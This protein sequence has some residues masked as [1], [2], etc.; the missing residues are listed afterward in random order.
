MEKLGVTN[1]T[2]FVKTVFDPLKT[3]GASDVYESWHLLNKERSQLMS[4]KKT[5]SH[6][7]FVTWAEKMKPGKIYRQL[8]DKIAIYQSENEENRLE[9]RK[10]FEEDKSDPHMPRKLADK[11]ERKLDKREDCE[12]IL[13]LFLW[14]IYREDISLLSFLYTENDAPVPQK[15]TALEEIRLLPHQISANPIYIGHEQLIRTIREK[16]LQNNHFVFIQGMGGI[17]KTETAK[18]YAKIYARCYD[19]VVFAECNS[20]LTDLLNDNTVFT[21]TK[22]FQSERFR[23]LDGQTETDAEFYQRKLTALRCAVNERTLL[24]LDNMDSQDEMLRDFL[25]V[26]CHVIVTTRW[27]SQTEYPEETILPDEINDPQ[28]CMKIFSAYYG[29]ELKNDSYAKKIIDYFSGHTL[30]LELTAKQMQA[31]ELSAEEMWQILASQSASELE[32]GFLLPN[33]SR[34]ARSMTAHI[35][36]IFNLT[37]LDKTQQSIL[38]CMALMPKGGLRKK[39]VR[40]F[41]GCKSYTELNNLVRRSWLRE[42]DGIVSMHTLIRETVQITCQPTLQSC[43]PFLIRLTETL[44]SMR[45][46]Y[47]ELEQ[48]DETYRIAAH[49][50]ESF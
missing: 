27:Q 7:S 12:A 28:E 36:Q 20:T 11:I 34:S 6:S 1:Q 3:H 29:K 42:L 5:N 8:I 13:L 31:S 45:C 16:L 39:Y 18:Q 46:Y 43:M 10:M 17:G 23:N 21:L 24:I 26:N 38:S 44:S 37:D 47:A 33:K 25:T 4:G 19:T 32:E 48:K 49:L 41:C 14:S 15:Q 30:A 35:R 22:P 40:D 2:E 9:F 50:F